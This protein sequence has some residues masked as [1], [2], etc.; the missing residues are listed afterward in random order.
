MVSHIL[1]AQRMTI[2]SFHL[3]LPHLSTRGPQR[4]AFL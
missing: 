2:F 3:Y 4:D 1:A